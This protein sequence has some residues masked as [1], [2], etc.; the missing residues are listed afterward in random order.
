MQSFKE[1]IKPDIK[2][3]CSQICTEKKLVITI[4]FVNTAALLLLGYPSPSASRIDL[5][6]IGSHL[7]YLKTWS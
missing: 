2:S 7:S 1:F 5:S 6:I 3:S 4:E